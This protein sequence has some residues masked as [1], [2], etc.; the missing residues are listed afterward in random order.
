[1]KAAI[2]TRYGPPEVLEIRDVAKPVPKDNRILIRIRAATVTQGDCEMR[3]FDMPFF[4]WLPL[5][6]IM[7]LRK[8]G[9]NI[10]GQEV[11]GEVEAV[12]KDVTHLREGD[13]VFGPTDIRL[14]GYAEYIALPAK[15][16]ARFDPEKIS[17]NEAATIPTGGLNALHF[18][19]KAR[20]REGEDV[21]ING[22]GGS[23]GT[24]AVQL[25]KARGARVTAVDSTPK[26][27]MLRSIGA[28]DVADYTKEDVTKRDRKYDVILDVWG[29][30]VPPR[31]IRA[32][33]PH[34]RYITANPSL[35]GL[36]YGLWISLT[37]AKKL[38]TGL[39]T[40]T[41]K[42]LEHLR[43]LMMT[44][45]LRAVIDRTYTLD[46]IVEAHRYVETG[47]KAGNV[48]IEV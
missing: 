42:D 30:R 27:E 47:Q 3:R 5:R 4:L 33:K 32:L 8:P 23:I 28:D 1:M 29:K 2:T 38:K 10:L 13:A 21:L 24:Y 41:L 18:V 17:F 7:G 22:A 46:Q 48:V 31:F 45:K 20:I 9:I 11:A 16:A 14:G 40:Y 39:A 37:S 43:D 25:I 6:F 34:G 26:L 19:R 15:V 44:G 35:S 36:I 12:G